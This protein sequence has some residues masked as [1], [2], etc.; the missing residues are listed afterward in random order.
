MNG[1]QEV[2]NSPSKPESWQ[3]LN[4][5]Q[6]RHSWFQAHTE[7]K[8]RLRKV[9]VGRWGGR[10]TDILSAREVMRGEGE[11]PRDSETVRIPVR[12]ERRGRICD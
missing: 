7:G 1:E 11:S 3:G 10:R 9:G 8:V 5:R 4:H 12:L 6:E 2:P